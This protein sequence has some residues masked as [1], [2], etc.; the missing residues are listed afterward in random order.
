MSVNPLRQ[1][2]LLLYSERDA[3]FNSS[4]VHVQVDNIAHLFLGL[5]DNL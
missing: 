1:L 5:L 3:T 4:S 2:L